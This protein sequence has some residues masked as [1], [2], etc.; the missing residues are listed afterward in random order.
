MVLSIKISKGIEYLYFQT[1]KDTLYIGP[2]NKPDKVKEKNVVRALVHVQNR[3]DH[4]TSSYDEL[5]SLLPSKTR[6]KYVTNEIAR[7]NDRVAIVNKV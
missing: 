5:L 7:L 2:K 4:Y 1:G 3:M 6:K